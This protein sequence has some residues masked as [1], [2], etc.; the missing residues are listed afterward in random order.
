M[1]RISYGFSLIDVIVGT[2]LML[3]IFLA[4][5]GVLRVSLVLSSLTKAKAAAVEVAN[6]QMEYLQGLAYA[7]LG[8]LNGIPAG[9]VPQNATSTVDGITYAV[10]TYIQYQDDPADG[11]GAAD[12]N[13]VTTDYKIGKVTVSYSLY[14]IPK[15]V[16]LVS[17][18][19]PPGIESS[20]G[21]GTLSLHVVN[22]AGTDV[23]NASVQIVNAS[24]SPAVNLTTIT[25]SNGLVL[26]GGAAT[27]S[28]YQIYVSRAG[29]SSAQTYPRTAQNVNP[30]PG[31]LTVAGNLTT[32]ATFAIDL[33]SAFTFSSFSSATTTTF[34]DIFADAS[35][36]SQQT[37]TQAVGGALSLVNNEFSGSARS[38]L[39]APSYL[40]GW[41]ILNAT[42]VQP[43]GSTAV[44]HITDASGALI[45]DAALTGNSAG[46]SAFPI[47]LTGIETSTY[48]NIMLSADL[49]RVA[50][51]TTVSVLDWSLSHTEGPI[52]YP[53]LAFTLT[54]AKT[55]GTNGGG[56]SIYKTTVNDTT[57]ASGSKTETLEWDGYTLSLVGTNLIESCP[58]SP[59]SFI[60]AQASTTALIV[61]A[62]GTNTLPVLIEDNTSNALSNAKVVLTRS[63]YAA[64]IPTTLCGL[65]YFNGIPAGTYSARVSANGHATTTF[66]NI[67]VNGHASTTVLTLP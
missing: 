26:I 54:G 13:N 36:L 67:S 10:R 63:G 50:T 12:T 32:S 9:P 30:T 61:G 20:T 15:S 29:Y 35:R 34:T 2:A 49:T 43:I 52:P 45:P 3:I 46:F 57:G 37:N 24:T 11:V 66:P 6:T 23:A 47:S 14:S 5:S 33:P 18:F 4:L 42:L 40:A 31:Y 27:S 56:Q 58:V 55:I 8:T 38:V 17:N 48:P 39:I 21:G 28:Q 62:L 25:D 7:S 41:G 65:A 19:A 51:S 16:T 1:R 59:Y 53:N 60:P 64:T 22:A 44:I